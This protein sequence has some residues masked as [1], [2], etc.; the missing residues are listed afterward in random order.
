MK[1][2]ILGAGAMGML[3]GGRL[4]KE[5]E[6]V[7]IDIDHTKVETINKD[8]IRIQE[9]DGRVAA[10]HPKAVF[11]A[12]RFGEMDLVIVFV[13][14]M[15]SQG[16]LTANKQL[17]GQGALVMS[18]QNGSGHDSV[19]K[20]F[21]APDKIVIGTT[22]HNSSIIEP[23]A[24]HHGGSGKTFIG[25]MTGD[26]SRLR[27]VEATLNRCGFETEISDNIQKKIWEKLFI[28]ASASA[29]TAVLQTKLGFLAE[30]EHAW[31]LVC[32]LIKEAVEVANGD[33]MG[34]DEDE[35]RAQVRGLLERAQ[36]GY[37]SIY[38]DIRDGRKTEVDTISGAVVAAS[39]RN[40]VPAPGH[41]FVVGLIHAMEH[42]REIQDNS[43]GK[44]Q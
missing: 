12:D 41:E 34:F 25:S 13:K 38:A 7:L 20:E 8:G 42:R 6:V 22:Q 2:A 14:S 36:D 44:R 37:T 4:S 23:G 15:D 1:I 32:R 29:L 30:S 39:K 27:A 9:P 10:F 40:G 11:S 35:I 19:M 31:L 21:A 24:V 16:A 18:L 28:N 43:R 3:F 17:I 26:G 5:N 33:G